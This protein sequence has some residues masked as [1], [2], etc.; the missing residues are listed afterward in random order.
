MG[1]CVYT[2]LKTLNLTTLS[3]SLSSTYSS[4]LS[5]YSLFNLAK[6]DEN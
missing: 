1:I 3:A 5:Q 2:L 4:D 6:R